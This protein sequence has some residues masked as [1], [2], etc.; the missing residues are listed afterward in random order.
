M[1]KMHLYCCVLTLFGLF[2]AG[3]LFLKQF[4]V[5]E[6]IMNKVDDDSKLRIFFEKVFGIRIVCKTRNKILLWREIRRGQRTMSDFGHGQ[7]IIPLVKGDYYDFDGGWMSSIRKGSGVRITFY[8]NGL[9]DIL[10]TYKDG[11]RY[12]PSLIW[13]EKGN[14]SFCGFF[15]L[16]GIRNGYFVRFYD[17]FAR[18]S[19]QQFKNRE[20]IGTKDSWY[21]TGCLSTRVYYIDGIATIHEHYSTNGTRVD[22]Q[23]MVH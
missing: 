8:T 21:E 5:P 18:R 10:E 16:G 22:V 14:L 4:G 13:T 9:P 15:A 11:Y 2:F 6:R 3:S 12:G 7:M 20:P 19:L 1:K 17:D 23:E